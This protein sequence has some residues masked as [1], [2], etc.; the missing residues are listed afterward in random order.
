MLYITLKFVHILLA[1]VAVG[2]TTSFGLIS[3]RAA[4]AG[5]REMIYALKTIALMSSIA[6]ACYI[7]LLVTGVWMIWVVGYPYSFT[8]IYLS[9]I[10][11]T[12]AFL[13]GSFM[14]VPSVKRRIKILGERGSSDPELIE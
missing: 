10:L 13:A 11:F 1:I 2:F 7:L 12:V 3:A 14:M 5:D 9:L 8:W 6:H 4:K